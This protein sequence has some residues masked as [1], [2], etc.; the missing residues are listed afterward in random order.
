MKGTADSSFEPG[1][2]ITRAQFVQVLH[3]LAG[4]PIIPYKNVFKDVK[5]NQWYTNAV[6]WALDKKITSGISS[7]AFGPE[8]G[9]T[10]EQMVTM[11]Y[12]YAKKSGRFYV[13]VDQYSLKNFTDSKIVSD[14]ATDA[15]RW[16]VTNG[17]ICGK[18]GKGGKLILDP[19]GKATRAECA[20]II[21]NVFNGCQ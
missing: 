12:K 21:L 11:L 4:N 14:W 2:I 1:S 19:K 20:Q 16:A 5:K 17:V 18:S 10:R 3:N 6:M 7:D 15:M 9:I 13:S 8:W